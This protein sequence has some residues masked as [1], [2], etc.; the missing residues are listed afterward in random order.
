[1]A[2]PSPD[3]CTETTNPNYTIGTF[4]LRV[5]ESGAAQDFSVGNITTGSFQF[6]P[7]ILEHRRGVDNEL[8][9][10]F[11]IGSDYIINATADEI[12]ARNMAMVLNESYVTVGGGC[13]IPLQGERCVRTYGVELVHDFPCEAKTLTIFFWRAQILAD[14][15]FNFDTGANASFPIVIRALACDTAHPTQRFGKLVFNEPCPVS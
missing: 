15:P 13:E 3:L 2:A 1:M 9:A 5:R 11:R 12:T 7:N 8:D 14:T 10:L 4:A 6:T